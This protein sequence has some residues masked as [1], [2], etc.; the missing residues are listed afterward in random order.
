MIRL[1]RREFTTAALAAPIAPR[2][3]GAQGAATPALEPVNIPPVTV[4]SGAAKL[5]V[6]LL[7]IMIYAPVYLAKEKGYYANRGLDVALN[8]LNAGTD[9]TLL[10]ATGQLQAALTG[11]GPA[12][13]NGLAA[14]LPLTLIAPG[15]EEGTPVATPL[16]VAADSPIQAVSELAGRKVSVNAPGGT[17]F[18]LDAAM[19][20]GGLTIDDVDLQFLG[21]PDAVTALDTGALAAAII[22]EP[23]ATQ[24]LRNSITR[25]LSDD[26]DVA[27]VQVT[28]LFANADW[29]AANHD[30]AVQFVAAY[31][32]AC[33]DL[34]DAPN[35]PLTLT[36]INKYTGVPLELIAA[37]VR[38]HYRPDGVITNDS[39]VALQRFFAERGQLDRADSI[40]PA[41]VTSQDVLDAAVAEVSA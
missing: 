2:L 13:W 40:D 32:E 7:P 38:P 17:E 16:L 30:V 4:P 39:L 31:L 25:V 3:A 28:A 33:R 19:R 26:F 21:F 22:G 27:G 41:T 18:W 20:S 9:L 29:V 36:I 23:V 24:S 6:G 35:D 8:P 5:S 37:S 1:T 15:H 10:T 14:D 34:N 12:F 11:I